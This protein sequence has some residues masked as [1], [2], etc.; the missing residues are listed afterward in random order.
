MT[1]LTTTFKY[2]LVDKYKKYYCLKGILDV[3]VLVTRASF[4][5]T[6]TKRVFCDFLF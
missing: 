3:L 4:H 6:T 2:A 1:H 5:N